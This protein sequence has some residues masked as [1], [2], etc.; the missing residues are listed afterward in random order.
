MKKTVGL[1]A[2]ALLSVYSCFCLPLHSA[3]AEETIEIF[4]GQESEKYTNETGV[5]QSAAM[6]N[7]GV[8]P[9]KYGLEKIGEE[10]NTF[11]RF[12]NFD[13]SSV[14]DTSVLMSLSTS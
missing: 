11:L 6:L 13:A 5:W 10:R 4:L 7:R 12:S 8:S 14:T 9:V 3:A 1:I 2:C